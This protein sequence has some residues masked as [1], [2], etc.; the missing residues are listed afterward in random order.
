MD[1]GCK[2]PMHERIR[3][4]KIKTSINL[5]SFEQIIHNNTYLTYQLFLTFKYTKYFKYVDSNERIRI[6]TSK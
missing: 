1:K 5:I 6:K 3:L 4:R 2:M